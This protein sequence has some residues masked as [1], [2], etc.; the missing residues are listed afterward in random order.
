MI[1][2]SLEI[3]YNLH[4]IY[5]EYKVFDMLTI[6]NSNS[7]L[8]LR[9]FY[10]NSL[11]EFDLAKKSL[12]AAIKNDAAKNDL[13][14][15]VHVLSQQ[16]FQH[17]ELINQANLF[18]EDSPF[19]D[20][21]FAC[22]NHEKQIVS[23]QI[24]SLKD[25]TELISTT[26]IEINQAKRNSFNLLRDIERINKSL[27]KNAKNVGTPNYQK[28][29]AFIEEKHKLLAEQQEIIKVLQQKIPKAIPKKLNSVLSK[30][31]ESLTIDYFPQRS[32]HWKVQNVDKT[33]LAQ[34][35][36]PLNADMGAFIHE[37]KRI[38]CFHI[39]AKLLQNNRRVLKGC[40]IQEAMKAHMVY[41]AKIARKDSKCENAHISMLPQIVILDHNRR[42]LMAKTNAEI[43]SEINLGEINK[44]FA[45]RKANLNQILNAADYA[46][47]ILNAVDEVSE[48]H[49]R[50]FVVRVLQAIIDG[51]P[52]DVAE[53]AF[54]LKV[55]STLDILAK[56][57]LEFTKV[58]NTEELTASYNDEE[59][60]WREPELLEA[61]KKS[62]EIADITLKTITGIR[63]ALTNSKLNKL[64]S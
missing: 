16:F 29:Q 5:T 31:I 2:I 54:R 60:S 46:H 61:C 39:V 58:D 20:K 6:S 45:H 57:L 63:A 55:I 30:P 52:I 4:P 15:Y 64:P 34:D 35:L 10:D 3:P 27:Q 12:L 37:Q 42:S 32:I 41:G 9:V 19:R 14:T 22:I 7:A 44:N 43:N 62:P 26:D 11:A 28:Q 33:G 49:D 13:S 51:L 50:K 40:N 1:V 38:A 18:F 24:K 23:R 25:L 17:L 48:A 47:W 21:V 59:I 53:N 36:R 56:R 8:D